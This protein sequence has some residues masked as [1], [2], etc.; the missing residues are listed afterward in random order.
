MRSGTGRTD[1][2]KLNSPFGASIPSQSYQ[3]TDEREDKQHCQAGERYGEVFRVSEG[4][5]ETD[6]ADGILR[7]RANVAHARDD[8]LEDVTALDTEQVD[9]IEHEEADALNVLTLLPVTRDTVPLLGRSED[10]VGAFESVKL[11]RRVA[12]QLEYALTETLTELLLPV[13]DA[14]AHEGLERA[15]VDDLEVRLGEELQHGQLGANGLRRQSEWHCRMQEVNELSVDL[16]GASWSAHENVHVGAIKPR[17]IP[18]N[19]SSRTEKVQSKRLTRR[20]LASA[21]G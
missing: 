8:D 4:G 19:L 13:L 7:L 12:R 17:R 5:A 9:L 2:W 21:H 18:I 20:I 15:N 6:E 16:A 11:G 1:G 10:D 14:L 3:E